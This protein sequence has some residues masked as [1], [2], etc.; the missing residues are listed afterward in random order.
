ML[1]IAAE[2]AGRA[3]KFPGARFIG[4]VA[5][6]STTAGTLG[7]VH[8]IS[9]IV[10]DEV[11]LNGGTGT[12]V[13][14][15]R[16][17]PNECHGGYD[18][19]VAGAKAEFNKKINIGTFSIPTTYKASET[20]NSVVKNEICNTGVDSKIEFDKK[21]NHLTWTVPAKSLTTRV[22]TKD[23]TDEGMFTSDNGAAAAVYKNFANLVKVL[24][25]GLDVKSA[26]ELRNR[27]QGWATLAAYTTSTEG[28]AS[29]AWKYVKPLYEK[30]LIKQAQ[31][32]ALFGGRKL[33]PSDITINLP[34]QVE[35]KNQYAGQLD[36][37][38]DDFGRDGVTI[39]RLDPNK[40]K[41]IESPKLNTGA[42][43]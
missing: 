28:C 6:T 17:P 11:T 9:G 8:G 4:L 22:Y 27:L 31:S 13:A 38:Q 26:D 34:D 15:Y 25:A 37:I 23:L 16:M 24:P 21:S 30:E 42:Q 40:L 39:H 36:K 1:S 19:E 18:T 20:F 33:S 7:F 12:I 14:A 43:E 32:N 5:L 3:T 2:M 29:I 35:F 10:E 41:C